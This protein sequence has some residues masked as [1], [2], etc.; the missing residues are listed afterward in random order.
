M[1]KINVALIGQG[2]MGRSHSNA[3]GQV[4]KFF[5]PPVRPAM[6]TVFGQAEENPRE[7]ADNWG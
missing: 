1:D 7:F 5:D 6:H 4:N 2:F 3:W